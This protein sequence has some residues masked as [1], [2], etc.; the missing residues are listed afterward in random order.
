[1][2]VSASSL[3]RAAPSAHPGKLELF[4]PETGKSVNR[5]SSRWHNKRR[6]SD[7]PWGF[8]MTLSFVPTHAPSAAPAASIAYRLIVLVQPSLS[9][10]ARTL[11]PTILL[12]TIMPIYKIMSDIVSFLLQLFSTNA[13]KTAQTYVASRWSD[14]ARSFY[15]TSFQSECHLFPTKYHVYFHRICAYFLHACCLCRLR[16]HDTIKLSIT[17]RFPPAM[18]KEVSLCCMK[19]VL[20]LNERDT[21][22]RLDLRAGCAP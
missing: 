20:N 21:V 4:S 9:R 6:E 3:R 8:A 13:V 11:L 18:K 14:A 5:A 10:Y 17:S 1:M 19:L 16:K 22:L 7:G 2:A 12:T 15:F